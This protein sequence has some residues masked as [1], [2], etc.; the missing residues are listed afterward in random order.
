[1]LWVIGCMAIVQVHVHTNVRYEYPSAAGI[2]LWLLRY[3]EL[4]ILAFYISM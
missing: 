4:E 3:I 2:Q 1:M